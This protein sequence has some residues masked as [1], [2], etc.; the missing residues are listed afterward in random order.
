M[1]MVTKDHVELKNKYLRKCVLMQSFSKITCCWYT[2]T[3]HEMCGSFATCY[4]LLSM[5]LKYNVA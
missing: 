2:I 4:N 1:I 5:Y 3:G